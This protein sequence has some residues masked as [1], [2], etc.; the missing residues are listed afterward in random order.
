MAKVDGKEAIA[1]RNPLS[2]EQEMMR[3]SSIPGM[4]GVMRYNINRKNTDLKLYE[5]GEVYFKEGADSFKERRNLAVGITGEVNDGWIAKARPVNLFDLKGMLEAL[6]SALGVN[7]FSTR[8]AKDAA[9]NAAACASIE[10]N[11]KALG[12]FGEID[13]DVAKNFDIKDKVY[14]LELDCEALLGASSLKKR[15]KEPARYPSVVR[16]ISIVI[17]S[18]VSNIDIV[19]SIRESAGALLKNAQL[20]DRYR[21]GQIPD[22][23]QSLT[24]RLEYQD[25]GRTLQD[26]EVQEAHSRVIRALQEKLGAGLR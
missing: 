9:F 25:T 24:Y 20:V 4:L 15:F 23:K 13:R 3:P 16:D 26:Q 17:N 2:G 6:L 8:E 5:L 21:G 19:S 14:A 10:V 12:I 11:G 22:G 7:G 18:G 1:V